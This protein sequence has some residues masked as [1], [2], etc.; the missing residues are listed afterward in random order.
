MYP[1]MII[2]L[3]QL[4]ALTGL[5]LTDLFRQPATF[6]LI[7]TNLAFTILVPLCVSHQIGQQSHLAVDSAL[8][9]EFVFGLILAGYAAC[10]TLH[11]ECRSGTILIVL[12]KPVSRMMFFLAKFAAVAFLLA[13]FVFCSSTAALLAERLAPQNFEFD[14][15]GLKLMLS[16][17]FVAFLPAGLLNFRNHRSFVP[18]ALCLYALVLVA[19]VLILSAFDREGQRV[20]F[21]SM[22][23]WSLIPACLLE[24]IALLPLAAIAISLS[25]R[26]A[27][28]ATVSI[29]LFLLFT[30]LISDY[31]VGLLQGGPWM[32]FTLRTILPDIQSFWPADKLADGGIISGRM[33]GHAAI[34]AVTYGGG[35][36]CLGYTAFRNRQF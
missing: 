26:L 25:T 3:R 30:G 12:S 31:L 16:S 24:G 14:S 18:T 36:L 5:A 33:L 21:G 32:A 15:F 22:I 7:L 1:V 34:Y 2:R 4:V 19:M 20:A 9:F 29:L 23:E 35:V 8:A 28:P 6:L 10:S 27:A 13:F 17:P 11:N